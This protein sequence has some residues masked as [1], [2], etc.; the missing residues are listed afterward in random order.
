MPFL[1]CGLIRQPLHLIV[2]IIS[3]HLLRFLSPG[4]CLQTMIR[5][6]I[7]FTRSRNQLRLSQSDDLVE[8]EIK[9]FEQRARQVDV[10]DLTPFY[11]S[12]LFQGAFTRDETN[13]RITRRTDV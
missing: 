10:H 3:L 1:Y 2:S 6:E 4:L 12:A 5:E 11:S 9:D 8:I 13:R 7:Q